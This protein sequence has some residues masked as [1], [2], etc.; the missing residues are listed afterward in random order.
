MLAIYYNVY[1]KHTQTLI[2][3]IYIY[4]VYIYL[5]YATLTRQCISPQSRLV[6]IFLPSSTWLFTW[7]MYFTWS[8]SYCSRWHVLRVITCEI[9]IC[10]VMMCN[11]MYFTWVQLYFHVNC[12]WLYMNV[13]FHVFKSEV[14]SFLIRWIH[15]STQL[16]VDTYISHVI[17]FEIR[18]LACRWHVSL[19]MCASRVITFIS[20]VIVCSAHVISCF[21]YVYDVC[22]HVWV[23]YWSRVSFQYLTY[24]HS[25]F[26]P[27][28]RVCINVQ[29]SYS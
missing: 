20:H 27:Y 23:V 28:S 26:L 13:S 24:F 2:G 6:A 5:I 8:L 21:I 3:Y 16:H 18:N 14:F 19:A 10:E 25:W 4:T 7:C 17:L 1:I 15:F 12:L 22:D 11:Q 9:V 29:T